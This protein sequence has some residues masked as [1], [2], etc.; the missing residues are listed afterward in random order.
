MIRVGARDRVTRVILDR[1]EKKN[2]LNWDM[3][4]PLADA[5]RTAEADTEC[6]CLVITGEGDTFCAG[7]DL[8]AGKGREGDLQ[9]VLADDDAYL[10]IF[11]ALRT[12]SK[13]SV[14]V[15]RGHAVAG[16]FTLAMACD[17]V[18]AERTARFGALEMRGGF[19]AAVNTAIL[20]H[21]VGPRHALE[22]LLSADSFSAERLHGMGLVNRLADGPEALQK[23]ADDMVQGL[24]DLEPVAVRLTK[25]TLRAVSAMP[26]GE[27]LTVSKQLNALLMASGRI[28]K[29]AEIF[30]RSKASRGKKGK[31]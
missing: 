12:L 7:R 5:I 16:G 19:P 13:P 1:P 3:I 18:V 10:A 25:E 23:V 4:P 31:A 30:A 11:E 2:A 22:L 21:L 9:E 27:A 6:R 8:G 28:E 26:L 14:A 24:V 15:V 17:F 29:A 20:S